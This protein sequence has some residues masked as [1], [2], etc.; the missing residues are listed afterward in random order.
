[1][2]NDG[3]KPIL[4]LTDELEKDPEAK[5]VQKEPEDK[6][7]E[8]KPVVRGLKRRKS[9]YKDFDVKQQ[10]FR[11]EYRLDQSMTMLGISG[12]LNLLKYLILLYLRKDIMSQIRI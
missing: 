8:Q 1:M 12:E 3:D 10:L 11:P 9:L 5:E 6:K 2:S 7:E 4:N